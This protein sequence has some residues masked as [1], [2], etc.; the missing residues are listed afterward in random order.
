MVISVI[1][2]SNATHSFQA[3]FGTVTE[4][5][6]NDHDK[7]TNR[8]L[9]DQHPIEAITGLAES[10]KQSLDKTYTHNQKSAS[11]EWRIEHGLNKMPAVTIQDSAGNTVIGEIEYVDM[12]TVVLSF[13]GA[14]S[15]K[16]YLN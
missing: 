12:N 4:V 13:S 11:K 1:K 3:R 10:L 9:P 16:A 5:I 6:T 8:D 2:N 14:F 15:G 7:L